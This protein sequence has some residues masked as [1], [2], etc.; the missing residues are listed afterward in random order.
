VKDGSPKFEMMRC[1]KR[2]VARK[3]FYLFK[4][5]SFLTASMTPSLTAGGASTLRQ[6]VPRFAAG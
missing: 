4:A 3:I 5:D 2:F 1:P 6:P